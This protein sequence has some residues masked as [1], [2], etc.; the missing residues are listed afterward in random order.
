MG[1][2]Q[3]GLSANYQTSTATLY[4]SQIS[5]DKCCFQIS[6]SN[7]CDGVAK[8]TSVLARLAKKYTLVAMFDEIQIFDQLMAYMSA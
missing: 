6:R 3:C 4:L 7:I 8:S 2:I 5:T 1:H